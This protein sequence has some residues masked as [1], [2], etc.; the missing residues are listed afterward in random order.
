[1]RASA[2][3]EAVRARQME[4]TGQMTAAELLGPLSSAL[5]AQEEEITQRYALARADLRLAYLRGT[6]VAGSAL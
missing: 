4:R 3:A 6:L 5:R 2:V 1:M